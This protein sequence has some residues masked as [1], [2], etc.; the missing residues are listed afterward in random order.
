MVRCTLA[1]AGWCEGTSGASVL[2]RQVPPRTTTPREACEGTR[3]HTHA[4][5]KAYLALEEGEAFPLTLDR[6][7]LPRQPTDEHP[8]DPDAYPL[9][10]HA[11]QSILHSIPLAIRE[12]TRRCHSISQKIIPSLISA[13]ESVHTDLHTDNSHATLRWPVRSCRRG[14]QREGRRA[15]TRPELVRGRAELRH[16]K[17]YIHTPPPARPP[18]TPN[19][20]QRRP[21]QNTK[22]RRPRYPR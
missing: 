11:I 10:R 12:N 4:A 21:P 17:I 8:S 5:R 15:Q 3:R 13:H 19:T 7:P 16:T 18:T 20:P 1:H 6:P 22:E 9:P 14:S 2:H